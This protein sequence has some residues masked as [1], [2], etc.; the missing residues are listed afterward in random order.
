[1]PEP[2]G[3][4][5]S[6]PLSDPLSGP[7]WAPFHSGERKRSESQVCLPRA[8]RPMGSGD[9]WGDEKGSVPG[10]SPQTG[11]WTWRAVAA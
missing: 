2:D 6:G 3:P 4:A 9:V 11:N 5:L 8:E 1:M 10:F 7:L